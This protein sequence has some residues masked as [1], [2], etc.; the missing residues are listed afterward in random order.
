MMGKVDEGPSTSIIS[1]ASI[2]SPIQMQSSTTLDQSSDPVPAIQNPSWM[3]YGALLQNVKQE[4][5]DDTRN[6]SGVASGS[7]AS[8]SPAS[9]REASNP[10]F[11]QCGNY[12]APSMSAVINQ[13]SSIIA[14]QGQHS[15]NY[16]VNNNFVSPTSRTQTSP[17]L[18]FGGQEKRLLVSEKKNGKTSKSG[19][20]NKTKLHKCKHCNFSTNNQDDYYTHLATHIKKGKD[21]HC[22]SCRFVTEFKHHL[23]YHMLNH[24]GVKPFKCEQCDYACVNK[25]M[26]NSHLKSHSPIHQYRCAD[27]EYTTKYCHSL[28]V[29]LRKYKH[30]PDV[31]L[32]PD[33]TPNPY[34]IIDVYGTRRGPKIKKVSNSET[35][36]LPST[37]TKFS[38]LGNTVKVENVEKTR[39]SPQLSTHT[40][41]PLPLNP[42]INPALLNPA[43]LLSMLPLSLFNPD[44]LMGYQNMVRGQ[45]EQ[46]ASQQTLANNILPPQQPNSDLPALNNLS[47]LPEMED[48]QENYDAIDLSSHNVNHSDDGDMKSEEFKTS[49]KDDLECRHCGIAYD[50]EVLHKIHMS[51]HRFNDPFTCNMCGE[52][53]GDKVK[54]SLHIAKVAH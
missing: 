25:S 1:A 12:P 31:V 19:S 27:C 30:E 13:L 50:E 41:P 43:A 53:C 15:P 4:P 8:T 2:M 48:T 26:L 6:D 5:I 37:G 42:L 3:G 7:S 33:G 38:N 45:L 39:S 51:Y 10:P 21:L 11:I 49:M 28:K 22:P 20:T 36:V 35:T 32:N 44:V 47:R 23:E 14:S 16:S 29:H 40:P 52:K 17:R 34:P 46:I 54:F 18:S 24:R 9:E